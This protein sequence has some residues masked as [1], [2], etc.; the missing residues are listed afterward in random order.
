MIKKK[1]LLVDKCMPMSNNYCRNCS[2]TMFS[3]CV[4]SS[5]TYRFLRIQGRKY[6]GGQLCY[7]VLVGSDMNVVCR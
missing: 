3:R 1:K 6:V 4:M 2:N 7:N 5:H